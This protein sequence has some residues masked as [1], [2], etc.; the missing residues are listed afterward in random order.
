MSKIS[1]KDFGGV[2]ISCRELARRIASSHHTVEMDL[3]E[4]QQA[5]AE[6]YDGRED[7]AYFTSYGD[8]GLQKA[9]LSDTRRNNAYKQAIANTVPGKVVLD[10]G[11][12]TGYLSFLAARAGATRVIGVEASEHMAWHAH[13]I[14]LANQLENVFITQAKV[15]DLELAEPLVDVIVSEWMGSFAFFESMLESVLIARDR[16][17]ASDG[18][19]LPSS[20]ELFAAPALYGNPD[21]AFWANIDGFDYSHVS[22]HLLDSKKS[23]PLH[24]EQIQ[25]S[26]L[27]SVGQRLVSHNLSEMQLSDLE[28]VVPLN[29][30]EFKSLK[31][32]AIDSICVY[33][34]VQFPDGKTEL[35]T[36]PGCDTH[37]NQEL[38]LLDETIENI[39]EE[40]DLISLSISIRRNTYWRRH[41]II[42]CTVK[43]IRDQVEL[44][45]VTKTFPHHRF[46][47]GAESESN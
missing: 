15:E 31:K 2:I 16:F 41:Y 44:F 14:C 33:F 36:A 22:K 27:A 6:G 19:M 23:Q 29:T 47:T 9:M 35:S 42:E 26:Q 28:N 10:V 38:L 1:R 40:S 4:Q 5:E 8:F 32:S 45:A 37:W 46:D 43:H 39:K 11:C 20:V 12:G 24:S 21:S 13:Q 30:L 3:S 25:P 34:A 7:D 17:L 18:E